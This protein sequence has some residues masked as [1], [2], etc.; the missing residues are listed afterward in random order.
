M[1]FPFPICFAP[2]LLN[3]ADECV[4]LCPL[5]SQCFRERKSEESIEGAM[6]VIFGEDSRAQGRCDH[7]RETTWE[8]QQYHQHRGAACKATTLGIRD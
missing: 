3:G 4:L 5:V 2:K 6:I 7:K 8:L 1:P